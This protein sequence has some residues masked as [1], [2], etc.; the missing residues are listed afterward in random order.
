MIT[1]DLPPQIE[2]IIIAQAQNQ[3]LSVENYLLEQI[4]NL[5]NQREL[6]GAESILLSMRDDFDEPLDDF[7]DYM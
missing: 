1:L 7:K 2:Q 5:V 4:A 6:G 3:G